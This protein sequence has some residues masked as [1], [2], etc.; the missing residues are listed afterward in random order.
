MSILISLF[1]GISSAFFLEYL[2]SSIKTAEDVSSY[3]NMPFLGY[4]PSVGKEANTDTDKSL[5][6]F[7]KPTSKISESYRAIRASLLFASP[8]DRPLKS[9]LITSSLPQ[10]GKSFFSLNLSIILCH[11]NERILLIDTDMRRPKIHKSFNFEHPVGLS[12]FL[13]GNAELKDIIKP[14]SNINN[15]F[16]ITAGAIPPNPSELLSSGKMRMLLEELKSKYDRIIIDSSPILSVADTSLLVSTVEGVI[17]LVKGGQTRLEVVVCSKNK[18][19]EAKGKIVGVVVNNID[20]ERED[21]YYYHYYY[22]E[23]GTKKQT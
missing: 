8:E 12:N 3:L 6:C 10:E 20:L 9:I 22:G 23:E 21:R 11:A 4:I 5:I 16:L 18:I 13:T 15:L 7:Q 19:L 1:L 14:A 2:D 17:L